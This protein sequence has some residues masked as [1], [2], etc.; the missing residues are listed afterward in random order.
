MRLDDR[1]LRVLVIIYLLLGI[2]VFTLVLAASVS[3]LLLR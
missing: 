1:L 3:R 2:A